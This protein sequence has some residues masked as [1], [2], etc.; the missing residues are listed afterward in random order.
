LTICQ[1]MDR[2]ADV[3]Q[4]ELVDSDVKDGDVVVEMG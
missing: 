3:M 2:T 1:L 4:N